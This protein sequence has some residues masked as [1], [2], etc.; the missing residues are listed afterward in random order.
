MGRGGEE[1]N[2]FD[3]ILSNE[4]VISDVLRIVSCV[5]P[6]PPWF[7][8]PLYTGTWRGLFACWNWRTLQHSY[9]HTTR[10]LPPMVSVR[11]RGW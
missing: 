9:P 4:T 5:P 2:Q 7:M 11:V 10:P 1:V 3:H 8:C 6:W